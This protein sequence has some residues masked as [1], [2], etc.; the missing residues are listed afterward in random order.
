MEEQKWWI[1]DLF[2]EDTLPIDVNRVLRGNRRDKMLPDTHGSIWM[3]LI[4]CEEQDPRR[5]S[6]RSASTRQEILKMLDLGDSK[7]PV[8]RLVTL[9]NNTS[10]KPRITKWCSSGLGVATFNLTSW[11]EMARRRIDEFWFETF[12]SI[13]DSVEGL[14]SGNAAQVKCE[15]VAQ[16]ADLRSPRQNEEIWGLFFPLFK[17]PPTRVRAEVSDQD[18]QRWRALNFLTQLPTPAYKAAYQFVLEHPNVVYC[19]PRVTIKEI[20]GI[21]ATVAAI[22]MHVSRWVNVNPARFS[23]REDNKPPLRED[24]CP[25]LKMAKGGDPKRSALELQQ[26]VFHFVRDRMHELTNEAIAWLLNDYDVSRDEYAD[27][28][29]HLVWRDLL[30]M[31]YQH[32]GPRFQGLAVINFNFCN[33]NTL[34]SKPM[35]GMPRVVANSINHHPEIEMNPALQGPEAWEERFRRVEAEILKWAIDRCERSLAKDNSALPDRTLAVIESELKKFVSVLTKHNVVG[36]TALDLPRNKSPPIPP[37]T[38]VI[39]VKPTAGQL[40]QSA[41]P[42]NE[43]DSGRPDVTDE[44]DRLLATARQVTPHYQDGEGIPGSSIESLLPARPFSTRHDRPRQ[45]ETGIASMS[46]CRERR[47]DQAVRKHSV[48]RASSQGS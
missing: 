33:P 26:A 37:S 44:H 42:V 40:A 45:E 39:S 19:D 27:R 36:P 41:I 14:S 3:E 9:W 43:I 18:A 25:A 20:R 1:C 47:I 35:S 11:D 5:F 30:V 28:F 46:G 6:G 21:G 34:F 29:D 31:V 13:L 24:F 17:K 38:Q 8:K 15:D 12:D 23:D 2:D 16:L 32:I 4:A 48:R 7:L 22:M 10:W